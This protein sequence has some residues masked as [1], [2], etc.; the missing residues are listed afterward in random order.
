MRIQFRGV[1]LNAHQTGFGGG[2]GAAVG[3]DFIA[4][5]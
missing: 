5:S 4:L 1:E 2:G 3:L